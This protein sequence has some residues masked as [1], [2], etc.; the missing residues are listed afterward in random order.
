MDLFRVK[1]NNCFKNCEILEPLPDRID[2][3]SL[4]GREVID[5]AHHEQSDDPRQ[6]DVADR[7]GNR[8]GVKIAADEGNLDQD[9]ESVADERRDVV[10][11]VNTAVGCKER[12]NVVVAEADEVIVDE[13][14]CGPGYQ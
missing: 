9:S 12:R 2:P 1:K 13:I 7:A 3:G 4:A 5:R 11:A 10:P 14:D 8:T 6:I